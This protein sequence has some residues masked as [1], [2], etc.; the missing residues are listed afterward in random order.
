LQAVVRPDGTVE[1]VRVLGGH[2]LLAEAA[3]QA[4]MKWRYEPRAKETIESVRISFGQ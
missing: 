2:P 4:L 1:K 3:A